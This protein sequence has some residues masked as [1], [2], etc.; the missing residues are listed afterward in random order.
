MP[1]GVAALRRSD[2]DTIYGCHRLGT[3]RPVIVEEGVYP[4]AP[5][6]LAIAKAYARGAGEL[7]GALGVSPR[8]GFFYHVVGHS[9]VH[10]RSDIHIQLLI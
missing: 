4:S 3:F 8:T 7:K 5:C 9:I 6:E 2:A 1:M 10:C